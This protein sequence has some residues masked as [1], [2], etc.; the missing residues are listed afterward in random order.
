LFRKI[1]LDAFDDFL[2]A[3]PASPAFREEFARYEFGHDRRSIDAAVQEGALHLDAPLRAPAFYT[4]VIGDLDV[5]GE[6]DLRSDYETGGLFIVLGNVRCRH[7]ISEYDAA[8]FIDGDLRTDGA[9]LIAYSDS[10]FSV[11][12]TMQARL[13]IGNDIWASVGDGAVIEYGEGYCA[14][15]GSDGTSGIVRPRHDTRATIRALAPQLQEN[16][17]PLDAETLAALIR[18]GKPIFE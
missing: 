14:S 2:A 17:H 12:G 18:A 7:F 10:S 6:I 13:L 3:A 8:V 11:V 9:V 16:S 15:L 5:E 4:L 1:P